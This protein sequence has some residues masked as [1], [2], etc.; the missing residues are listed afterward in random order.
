MERQS[1]V[2]SSTYFSSRQN[3]T[4]LSVDGG[5]P[6]LRLRHHDLQPLGG[7]DP[8]S[9]PPCGATQQKRNVALPRTGACQHATG[10]HDASDQR[11]A[12]DQWSTHGGTAN[13]RTPSGVGQP[14]AHP[15]YPVSGSRSL[16]FPSSFRGGAEELFPS[17]GHVVGAETQRPPGGVASR[18]QGA[19]D[20]QPSASGDGPRR[21]SLIPKSDLTKIV[22]A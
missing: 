2:C 7:P 3:L 21:P 10:D 4:K 15:L 12:S 20:Q 14:Q 8:A 5:N 9:S 18:L 17:G 13:R 11:P 1:S 22:L 19:S 6:S 16:G